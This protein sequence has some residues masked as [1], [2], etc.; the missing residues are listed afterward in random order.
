MLSSGFVRLT[1]MQIGSADAAASSLTLHLPF[2]QAVERTDGSGQFHGG[3]IASLIDTAACFAVVMVTD[4]PA[5]TMNL[6]TDYL[7]PAMT[8]A[9]TA[10]ASV[11]R[12]GRTVAVVDVDVADAS[13]R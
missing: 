1:G 4:A 2:S 10:R 9:L 13:G 12:A 11:R 6:R 5:P 7:R 3:A 8:D